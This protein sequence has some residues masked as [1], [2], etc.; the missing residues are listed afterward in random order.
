MS[1]MNFHRPASGALADFQNAFADALFDDATPASAEVAALTAQPAFAVY[2]NTVMKACID[3]LQ[4][5]YPAVNRL[6]GEEWFRAAAAVYARG[7][8]PDQPMLL[9]YGTDFAAFL[10]TFE[11]AAELPY[12]PGV[13]Q[14][15]RHWIEAHV[16][17][18]D[19]P[20][21][22]DAVAGLAAG[23]FFRVQLKP[24]AAAR[25]QWFD[26]APVYTIWSRNRSDA[27]I[28]TEFA[29][30]GEGALLTRP[31]DVVRWTALDH[32]GCAFLDACAA[33]ASLAGAAQAA[34]EIDGDADLAAL[35]SKLLDAGVFS[36]MS[37]DHHNHQEEP[38]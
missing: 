9:Q 38:T 19:A 1:G 2:R 24:H 21:E 28:D 4:A 7:H 22:G 26:D 34:L 8:L 30:H 31:R 35:I 6:V 5:N 3:A 11:P 32:A 17:A 16:S 29:W 25:W 14:L 20:L 10:A 23:N 18:D 36:G 37:L 13:A 27:A 12:L 15:D 33:G